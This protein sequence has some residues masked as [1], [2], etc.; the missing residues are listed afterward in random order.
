MIVGGD[1]TFYQ[2][3]QVD[4]RVSL[5]PLIQT[6]MKMS[7]PAWSKPHLP[8]SLLLN[9]IQPKAFLQQERLITGKITD[10]CR[11]NM[12]CRSVLSHR[13]YHTSALTMW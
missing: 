2:F 4:R 6:G 8:A 12:K 10:T 3:D 13:G 5:A 9:P 7:S 1:I 11:T